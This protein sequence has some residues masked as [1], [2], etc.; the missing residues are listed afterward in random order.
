MKIYN[1]LKLKIFFLL[2]YLDNFLKLRPQKETKDFMSFL[3]GTIIYI[4]SLKKKIKII[5]VGAN[6]GILGDP[7]Y[8]I[9]KSYNS[10]IQYVGIEPDETVFQKLTYNYSKLQN[11]FLVN[12]LI[13]D[14]SSVDFYSFNENFKKFTKKDPSGLNSIIK[15]SM[16]RQLHIRGL[17]NFDKWVNVKKQKSY[18]LK[19]ALQNFPFMMK[20]DI[21]QVDAEGFDDE[22]IYNSSIDEFDF[23]IINF[24]HK[25]LTNEKCDKLENYLKEKKYEIFKWSKS[26]TLAIKFH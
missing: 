9:I 16:I 19:Q 21:L 5:Q 7:L 3:E 17:K 8:K 1:L 12:K 24:E 22:I 20:A 13:G 18:T 14:G 15:E 10:D 25:L 4:L 26:D 23:K 6:D 2:K 11:V